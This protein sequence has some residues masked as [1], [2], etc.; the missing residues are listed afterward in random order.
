MKR[1]KVRWTEVREGYVWAKDEEDVSNQDCPDDGKFIEWDG[2]LEIV[3]MVEDDP[4]YG[5]DE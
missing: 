1:F 3:E 4:N 5:R 2:D